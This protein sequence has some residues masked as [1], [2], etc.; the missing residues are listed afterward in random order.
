MKIKIIF[1]L[2]LTVSLGVGIRF[3][4]L[5]KPALT[6]A[7]KTA[8]AYERYNYGGVDLKI[9][10]FATQPNTIFRS[11]SLFHDRILQ[12]Q[13]AERGW[14]MRE[15]RF[16]DGGAMLPYTDGR[17]DVL[18][19]GDIPSLVAMSR[20][21]IG[22]FAVCRQGYNTI[23][24]H[25]RMTPPELKGLRIGYPPGTSAHFTLDRTLNAVGLTFNDIVPVPM[26][27]DEMVAAMQNRRVDVIVSWEPTASQVLTIPG[28]AAIA[29]T[30]GFSYIAFD[31]DF[32][33]HHP[34]IQKAILAA[35]VRATR[36]I[37]ANEKNIS[38]SLL[39][40]RS[41]AIDFLGASSLDDS[42]KW[43]TLMRRET[44]DNPSF[45]MLPLNFS[46]KNGLP[47]QQFEFLKKTGGIPGN[48]LWE[49]VQERV[50]TAL[51]PEIIR[52]GQ[53]WQINRFDYAPDKLY[54]PPQDR[55]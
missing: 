1:I 52:D 23:I 55:P 41:A 37:R 47:Y 28:T 39:W 32:A 21:R 34:D 8:P 26:P 40:D 33:A 53:K 25:R 12:Q 48:I 49:T 46:E 16:R 20:H 45:P 50:N 14:T 4:L 11:E 24:A 27:P 31:L 6:G 22:I 5:Q 3:A 9:I 18:V 15:H 54:L 35:V 44:V 29:V 7:Q 51:L 43:I 13:L 30:E 2:I 36:W 19:L 42:A 10:D 38:E 17:L